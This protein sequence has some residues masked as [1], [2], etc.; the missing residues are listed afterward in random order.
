MSS[1]PAPPP[2][3]SVS[4]ARKAWEKQTQDMRRESGRIDWSKIDPSK[5]SPKDIGVSFGPVMTK[6]EFDEYRRRKGSVHVIPAA[7]KK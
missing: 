5:I 6:E 2:P 3:P 1:P 4:D 7:P